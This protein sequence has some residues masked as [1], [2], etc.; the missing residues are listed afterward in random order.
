MI[1]IALYGVL[2]ASVAVSLFTGR[3]TLLYAI[4]LL[5]PLTQALPHPLG[6]PTAPTNL[7]LLG[8]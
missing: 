4:A 8:P 5:V 2:V 1:N 3:K 7:M 6:M